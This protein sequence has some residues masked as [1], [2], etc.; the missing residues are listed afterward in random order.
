MDYLFGP[1]NPW[2]EN[3][4]W[5]TERYE[6]RELPDIMRLL[7]LKNIKNL[8]HQ[9]LSVPGVLE[10]P[11]LCIKW[12]AHFSRKFPLQIFYIILSKEPIPNCNTTPMRCRKLYQDGEIRNTIKK[13]SPSSSR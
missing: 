7:D 5:D 1:L 13:T 6:R 2:W 10:K 12:F 8:V 4:N 9:F 11:H 3:A